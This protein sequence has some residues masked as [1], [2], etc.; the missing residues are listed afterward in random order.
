VI[1]E[2]LVHIEKGKEGR[3]YWTLILMMLMQTC[4]QIAHREG[5][6]L[7]PRSGLTNFIFDVVV[8]ILNFVGVADSFCVSISI[9]FYVSPART[10][11]ILNAYYY[12][13]L[14]CTPPPTFEAKLSGI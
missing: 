9:L 14:I 1:G 7:G 8:D 6:S 11:L 3:A 10:P 5:P 4:H 13:Y 2:A 12:L